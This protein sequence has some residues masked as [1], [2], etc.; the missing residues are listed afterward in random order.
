MTTDLDQLEQELLTRARQAWPDLKV[1][2]DVFVQTLHHAASALVEDQSGSLG[3]AMRQLHVEDLYLACGCLAGDRQA[4][5]QFE[6]LYMSD[7]ERALRSL[8]RSGVDID[9]VLQRV[10]RNLLVQEDGRLPRLGQY[11]GRG[12]LRRWLRVAALREGL[13]AIRSA[14]REMARAE[15]TLLHAVEHDDDP[16]LQVLKRLYRAEFKNAFQQ[17]LLELGPRDRTLLRYQLVD[18]LNIDQIGAIYGVHRA[19][20][21][22]WLS[23]TRDQLRERSRELLAAHARIRT[24]EV[25]SIVRLIHSQLDVSLF[26]LLKAQ[27]GGADDENS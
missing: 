16:E 14:G 2:D 20:A 6:Q 3:A 21:A 17:A 10:R 13:S 11:T 4:L 15:K 24:E 5:E 1:A 8:A 18:G 12:A 9:E 25:D 19:T 7:L 26:R 22:R 27:E 23:H